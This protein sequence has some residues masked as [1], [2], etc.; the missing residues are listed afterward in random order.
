[1]QSK[2]L[3]LKGTLRSL[4]LI[5]LLFVAGITNA[6]NGNITFADPAVKAICVANWDGILGDDPDGELTYAEAAAVTELGG[7]FSE[8]DEIT[9][10]NEL[11]Y[12]TSL[13]TIDD[14]TFLNCTGLTSITLPSSVATIGTNAFAVCSSLTSI[15]IPSGVTSIVNNP[16]ADCSALA[17]ITVAAGNT[18]YDSRWGCNAII[19]T[20]TNQLVTGCKNTVIPE[21]V[22]SIGSYAL[23]GCTGLTSVAIPNGVTS[24]GNYAFTS[25]TNLTTITLSVSVVSIGDNAFR[26][27]TGLTSITVEANT[28][29]AL[30]N[31]TF[32]NVSTG[33]PVN[34]PCNTKA[35]FQVALGWSTFTNFVDPCE[36]I[37]FD[38]SAVETICLANWDGILG[39]TP[40]GELSYLEAAAVNNLGLVF[41][42]HSEITSFNELQYFTGLTSIPAYAFYG[43][44]GLTSIIIPNGID[45][46]GEV[47]FF[48]CTSLTS[49]NIPSSVTA[50]GTNPFVGCSA[51]ASITVEAG[52]VVL[53][54]RDN[55]NAIIIT[56]SNVLYS[57][58]MNTVIPSTVTYIGYHAFNGC[59]NLTSINIP[60]GVTYIDYNAF[61][62]CTGLTSITIPDGVTS[63]SN[64]TFYGC[65]GL[66]S[67]T[68]PSGLTTI[69]N[70]AFYG[71]IGLLSVTIPS[72]VT[73]IGNNAFIGCMSLSS[74]TIPSNVTTIGY[75]AFAYCN[76]LTSIT[77]EATTPPTL[78]T[79]AF[80]NVPTGIIV[81][82]PCGTKALYQAASGWNTFTNFVDPCGGI[83]F[84]DPA[85]ETLC[86][87][88]WDGILGDTPNGELSYL[89]AAA[90]NNLGLVFY[91]N[92]EITSFNELQYFT[93]LTSIGGLAFGYCSGLTS[94]ILPS[95]VT[96]IDFEAFADCSSL[97]SIT[98][99]SSVTSISNNPFK[100]C[101]ALA[102]I[103]VDAGNPVYDSRDNCNA[104]IKTSTN[105]LVTGCKNTVIPAAITSIGHSAF[106]GCTDMTSVTLPSGLTSINI[107][108]FSSCTGLTS[109]TLPNSLTSLGSYAFMSCSSLTSIT[110]PSSI[111]Q[112]SANVFN[113]CTGL[114]SVELPNTLTSIGEKAFFDCVSLAS[115]T[116]PSG[117][118]SIGNSAF[119]NC[120]SLESITFPSSLVNIYAWAFNNC[121]GLTSITV[122]ATTPPT[123]EDYAFYLVNT[124]I[125]VY[126]PCGHYD[127]YYIANWGGFTNFVENCNIVFAD[128]NVK[129]LC[130]ANWDTNGDN[131][132]SYSEAAAV[133]TLNISGSPSP[134]PFYETNITSFDELQYFTGLTSICDEAFYHCNNLVSVTLPGSVTTI[135]NAAF[136]DC[137]SLT[138]INIPNGVTTIALYAFCRCTSLPSISLPS[139]VTVINDGAF[140]DCTGLTSITVEATT[141]PALGDGVFRN[142]P[143]DI[144]VYVPC[145]YYEAYNYVD[146]GGFTNFIGQ[147]CSQES[148]LVNGWNWW[149]P[150]VAMT[151]EQLETG[152]GSAG[153]LINSQEGGFARYEVGEGWSGTLSEIEVGK[154]YKIETSTAYTLSLQ[155]DRPATVT[156]TLMPGYTWFGYTGAQAKAIATALGDFTPTNGD[157][158]ISQD[159]TVAIYNDG[160]SGAFTTL[161]PEHGYVYYST[162]TT[163]KTLSF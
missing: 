132:L 76:G 108:A 21:M 52:N 60:S 38:D 19:E 161:E 95:S 72:G 63:I 69:G 70:D 53:D 88:N 116:L 12:F 82:V 140:Q 46:I 66:T 124:S 136:I 123:L 147:G 79:N 152:L 130:V 117:L 25:C 103:T 4:L 35:A 3:L 57:G 14:E 59:T 26:G 151:V 154:M 126:V 65:T 44:T 145:G 134:S 23:C 71:C 10:F 133:T 5:L 96:S 109:V 24:I 48:G 32:L 139:T 49:I 31:Y 121:T 16:F 75:T 42:G 149:V 27:C 112:L 50:L 131:E 160:W 64:G 40:N 62:G 90:V 92:T 143:A 115:I 111:T 144:P 41:N 39:D 99:P 94:V 100:G 153:L 101:S 102:S 113:E 17:E 156:V 138:S 97:T 163:T 47:A 81:N 68:L 13:T 22:T 36:A 155:G 78:G 104:I 105:H 28:P 33:I 73:T 11:Q 83:V 150:T 58:C 77:V 159:G 118:T 84:D 6:Q 89:E 120:T 56:A 34:V 30:G 43:C 114:T 146:W 128:A 127:A 158:I 141:P 54:S 85:V 86:L 1:M 80:Q 8:N 148:A 7:M 20:A 18:V 122:E 91:G 87:A 142:V 51:L 37:D 106:Y 15:T 61:Y 137:T 55:C 67:V 162:A 110:I 125:L 157:K 107:Y 74:L 2:N 119:Y 29:P 93:G 45:Y 9:S 129:T 135:G 98:I